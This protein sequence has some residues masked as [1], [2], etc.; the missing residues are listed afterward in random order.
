MSTTKKV[1]KKVATRSSKKVPK[2]GSCNSISKQLSKLKSQLSE[3]IRRALA[4]LQEDLHSAS[5]GQK[6]AIVAEIKMIRADMQKNSP[7]AKAIAAKT[8][9]LKQCVADKGV[10]ALSTRFR[11]KATVT[12]SN[13]HARG[14]Y[15]KNV[16]IGLT[17]SACDHRT[18]SVTSFPPISFTYRVPLLG[19]VKTTVRLISAVGRFNWATR[20]IEIDMKLLFDH[21]RVFKDSRLTITLKSIKPMSSTG[22]VTLRGSSRFAG[23]ALDKDKCNMTLVGKISPPPGQSGN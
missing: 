18:I 1:A 14:P 10:P 15:T 8:K 6:A 5:P 16:T 12:T 23:G 13:K 17:F 9:E 21:S 19:S 2:C 11:G 4:P 7:L 20:R 3:A 22:V